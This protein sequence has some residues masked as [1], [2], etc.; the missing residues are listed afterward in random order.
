MSAFRSEVIRGL[1]RQKLFVFLYVLEEP[2]E[3]PYFCL[4]RYLMPLLLSCCLELAVHLQVYQ[5]NSEYLKYANGF[6]NYSFL[7]TPSQLEN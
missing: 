6:H 7:R 5:V 4:N 2:S 3:V 1:G